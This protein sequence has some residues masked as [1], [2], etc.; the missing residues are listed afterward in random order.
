[1]QKMQLK[2]ENHLR[3][4]ETLVVESER[5]YCVKFRR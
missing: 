4:W 1:M 2:G 5:D 3:W